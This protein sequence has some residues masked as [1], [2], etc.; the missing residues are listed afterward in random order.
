M[1]RRWYVP[2]M[3][4]P[5]VIAT[6]VAVAVGVASASPGLNHHAAAARPV[7]VHVSPGAPML[8]PPGAAMP[9]RSSNSNIPMTSTNWAGYVVA[10]NRPGTFRGVSS[11]W[12][13]PRANCAG[14]P[15]HRLA[16][17][18]VG[19][20]G[21]GSGSVEQTGA[22]SDCRG[23]IPSYQG[24][25]EMF[26]AAPV[27]FANRIV[28]GDHMTASVAFRGTRTYIL[29]LMDRTR[30][31]SHTIVKNQAGLTRA[32]AEVIVEAPS[33]ETPGGPQVLPLA[34]FGSVV[35]TGS[36]VNG[37]LLR[38]WASIQLTMVDGA[39]R[40]K[41]TTSGFGGGGAFVNRYVRAT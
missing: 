15:G 3:A 26:P 40:V 7:A 17:F 41:C 35:W 33:L 16:A 28:P 37:L 36:R 11:N 30:R 6:V 2:L 21:F 1:A 38:R 34:N 27:F 5:V 14:V 13:Q 19:L 4:L 24:W 25:F 10:S 12:V 22:D 32:S 8:L 20:D 31:W 39:H 18:W 9:T 29:V 23:R